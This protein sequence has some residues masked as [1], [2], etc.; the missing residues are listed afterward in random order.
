M[1]DWRGHTLSKGNTLETYSTAGSLWYRFQLLR[2]YREV[3][4]IATV[5]CMCYTHTVQIY[6]FPEHTMCSL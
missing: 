5:P 2:T 4:Q 1:L 6:T 3:L